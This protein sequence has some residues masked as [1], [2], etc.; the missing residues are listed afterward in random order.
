MKLQPNSVKIFAIL[1]CVIAFIILTT[2]YTGKKIYSEDELINL[3]DNAL[4][5]SKEK[6]DPSACAQLQE[7]VTYEGSGPKGISMGN[8]NAS[9]KTICL[10]KYYKE[11]LDPSA[12][13]LMDT[14]NA[15]TCHTY[16]AKIYSEFNKTTM[17][18]QDILAPQDGI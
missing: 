12:C 13:V 4:E 11:A 10:T 5:I 15:S 18:T 6:H 9:P 17:M 1:S 8:F 7:D 2:S 16:F 3:I 14:A